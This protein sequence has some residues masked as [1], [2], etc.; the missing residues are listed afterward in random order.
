MI[1]KLKIENFKSI[2]KQEFIFKP[3][4][5]LTG[6][7]SSGKSSIIQ[8][9]LFYSHCANPNLYL[10]EYLNNFGELSKLS[11]FTSKNKEIKITPSIDDKNEPTL[12]LNCE[13]SQWNKLNN[14]QFPSFE[15]E[16][17]YLSA[18]R[19]GQENIA[20]KNKN[21]RSGA[22]G[23]F[24]F[25][26]YE[27]NKNEALQNNKLLWDK[28]S[29]SLSIQVIFWLE[30]ILELKLE[31]KTQTINSQYVRISYE[32]KDLV[33]LELS[34]FNLGAGISYLTKI[35]ILGLSL[36]PNN[37]LIIENPEVH[38][39]PKAISKLAQFLAFLTKAGIQVFV[40]THSEHILNKM[41]YLVFKEELPQENVQIYYKEH[42]DENFTSININKRGKYTDE[43]GQVV[44]FPKGFFDSD[45]DELLEM[46]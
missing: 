23:E 28:N 21:L 26:F 41:R 37:F 43:K 18:N 40:E 45:L 24:L 42:K 5:I 38:L 6:T 20:Q 16:L 12:S 25:G 46:M 3:L 17:F 7:N 29:S 35:L 19:I 9:L 39:H 27:E 22:N 1:T 4:T 14:T 36:K 33:G 34:P 44:K 31:P 10:D 32:N 8:S 15:K 30:K 2:V 13:N 11:S